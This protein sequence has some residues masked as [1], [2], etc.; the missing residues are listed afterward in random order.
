MS[1]STL[2]LYEASEAVEYL[3]D[4]LYELEG[5]LTPE[6]E[7]LIEKAE[8]DFNAK[9]ERVVLFIREMNTN[10]K[11]I[12]EE[13]ARLTA[14]AAQYEK[15][16]A[17]L[18]TYLQLQMERAE[19]PKVEGKLASARLQ[20]SPPSV[21]GD[22]TVEQL[23]NLIETGSPQFVTVVPEQ[24]ALNKKEVIAWWKATGDLGPLGLAGVAVEQHNHVR[25]S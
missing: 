23:R 17:G 13:A 14:R 4:C 18:K 16:A 25:I 7:E 5:E 19:I 3:R 9:V 22:A 15:T 12:K 10:A 11:A 24:L 6:I 20:K 2:R 8:G 1:A 21:V